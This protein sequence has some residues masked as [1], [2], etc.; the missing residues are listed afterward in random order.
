VRTTPIPNAAR[1]RSRTRAIP[2]ARLNLIVL[3]RV[4]IETVCRL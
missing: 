1:S 2:A 4:S 3:A